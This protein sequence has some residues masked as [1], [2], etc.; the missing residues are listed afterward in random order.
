MGD[1][2]FDIRSGRVIAIDTADLRHAAALFDDAV[3][4][5]GR[6]RS[7]VADA[8]SN[9]YSSPASPMAQRLIGRVDGIIARGSELATGLRQAASMYELV[10]LD[11]RRAAAAAAGDARGAERLGREAERLA[12]SDPYAAAL[13]DAARMSAPDPHADVLRQLALGGLP[14][15][16]LGLLAFSLGATALGGVKVAGLGAVPH[17]SRLRPGAPRPRVTLVEAAPGSAPRALRDVARRIPTGGPGGIRVE[18]YTLPGGGHRFALYLSGTRTLGG[19]GVFD[20]EANLRVYFGQESQSYEAARMALERAGARPGDSVMVSGHSQGAM[21]GSRLAL[22]GEYDVPAFV[23]FGN[24]IQADLGEKTLQVDVRHTD[25]PV[26]ALAAGGHDAGMGAPGSFVAERSADPLPSFDD[27]K[28]AVHQ[29]D[30]YAESAGMLDASTD[31]RM[32]VVRERLREFG[33][34]ESVEVF[35][36]DAESA[37]SAAS[38]AGEG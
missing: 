33:A 37:V 30:V 24:P 16:A 3:A 34:A 36:F 20:V 28:V 29:M 15:G 22:E 13:A 9:L 27:L 1:D 35:V 21:I 7:S 25:D 19:P 5:A 10:E 2:G 11:A 8:A 31:P 12:E 6:L 18:K 32:E 23:G 4:D 26:S 38:S 17:S 14:F